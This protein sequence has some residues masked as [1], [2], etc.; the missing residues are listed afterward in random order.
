MS[1]LDELEALH[2]PSRGPYDWTGPVC[3][4]CDADGW[5]AENPT[6]PC[7]TAAILWPDPDEQA[8]VLADWQEW[9][10][11]T[12]ELAR[13]EREAHPKI[14]FIPEV[15]GAGIA[16]MLQRPPITFLKVQR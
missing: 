9:A 4:G 8:A 2:A 10:D 6:W 15:W 11:Q 12:S 1:V 5:E 13:K 7:R 3:V 16:E 14:T